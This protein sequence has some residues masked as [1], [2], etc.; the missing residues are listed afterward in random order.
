MATKRKNNPTY[1][2]Y[3]SS[4][5]GIVDHG[6]LKSFHTFSFGT[7]FNPERIQF[8]A[9]RVF[10]DDSVEGGMGFGE[11]PHD[12]MEIISIP[13]EG[14][15]EHKD[16]LGNTT[17]IKAGE[18]QVMSA[19]TGVYHTEYNKN[20]QIPVKF[21]Q[22]WIFPKLRNVQPRYDQLD[23]SSKLEK[24]TLLQILSPFEHDEGVWIH[25]DA[26]MHI[27]SFDENHTLD[28]SLKKKDDGLFIFVI[29]G[30]ILVDGHILNAR[31]AIGL[32]ELTHFQATVKRN[33]RILLI[34]VPPPYSNR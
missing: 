15:L 8:G 34:E 12:N 17:C 32:F 11:H 22:I 31:D 6:W 16:S 3:K 21:L 30:S 27:G 24:N 33:A 10:N 23:F 25:Q 28:Y 2:I 14:Q 1:T 4:N 9:L 5:R 7:Y 29:E 26:W 18:I 13:L 19:G 20:K